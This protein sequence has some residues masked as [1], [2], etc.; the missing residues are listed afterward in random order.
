MSNA[1][2]RFD[3]SGGGAAA[4]DLRAAERFCQ[5]M[6]RREAGNFYWGFISLPRDQRVAIYAL[7]DFAREVD[8][9]VDAAGRPHLAASLE[10]HR[11]RAH[12]CALGQSS[13]PVMLVLA[14]AVRRYGIP[15]SDLQALIDGVQAD[16]TRTR[17]ATWPELE[18]Y[19]KLV[20]STIGRMC[21]RIFGFSDPSALAHADE[22]GVAL[23]ITNIL[24]D[25][26]EDAGMG[27][28]YLP[29]EDLAR[30]DVA[31]ADLLAGRPGPG[32]EALVA[33]EAS[34]ARVAF[35]SGRR[36]LDLVPRRAAVCVGTMAGIYARLLDMIE[37]DPWLP[38]RRRASLSPAAK[39]GV[40]VRSCAARA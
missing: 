5:R 34:R 39:L 29:A 31:E 8:D 17:Y 28:V 21:V 27:R 1:L 40:M 30:F 36:V 20:A 25:V 6:A 16:L 38:L 23:Q 4:L 12:A 10:R 22:L 11:R 26:K 24:R 7:Y 3:R 33:F 19:C 14:R 13:D 2:E 15:E 18:A 37:R 9:E 32:W 35:A